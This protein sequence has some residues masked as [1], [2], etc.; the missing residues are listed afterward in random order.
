MLAPACAAE[1]VSIEAQIDGV[2]GGLDFSALSDIRLTL[3]G[4]EGE[5]GV[6]ETAR[7]LAQGASLSPE[8]MLSGALRLFGRQAAKLGALMLSIMLPVLLASLVT[9]TLAADGGAVSSLGRSVCFMLVLIPVMLCVLAELEHAQETITETTR[10]MEQLLPMLLTLLTAVGGSASSAFLHPVVVAASGSMVVLAREVILRLVMCTCAVTAVN[11][12]S[13]R[14]HLTR[15][16]HLLRSAVCW[17]LGVSFTV[18]LGAMSM[19]GVCSAS[20]DGVAIRAAKYA[21]DNFVPVVGGM[22]SDTM[23]T[24]VGCTLIVKN[25]LGVASVLVLCGALAAPLLRTLAAV[26][27]LKL[28]AALLEPVADAEIVRAVGD[29]SRT[30]VLLLI[31]M[32]CVGTMYFL[33]IVQLLLVG[34]LTVLLR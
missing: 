29:F 28:S 24:L 21:V 8:D 17:L 25:A 15:L 13:D 5:M 30:I 7:A 27:A 22:F 32:L 16:A 18:F 10:R 6:K 20:I 11:H 34:N 19:Q 23:D 12:L 1:E 3:P 31:T 9:H 2:L 4:Q 26:F 33:L 14:A